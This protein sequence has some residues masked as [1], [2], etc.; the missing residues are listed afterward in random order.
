MLVLVHQPIFAPTFKNSQW[1]AHRCI[2]EKLKLYV[3][4]QN[5]GQSK[6]IMANYPKTKYTPETACAY[7]GQI[8]P[9]QQ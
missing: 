8:N 9:Q 6:L 5:K 2:P 3:S 4:E 1:E 7:L